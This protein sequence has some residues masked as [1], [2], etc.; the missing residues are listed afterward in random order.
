MVVAEYGGSAPIID[1]ARPIDIL[2]TQYRA[3]KRFGVAPADYRGMFYND[4][5][6]E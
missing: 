2:G 3:T 6:A 4:G 5:T 1:Q